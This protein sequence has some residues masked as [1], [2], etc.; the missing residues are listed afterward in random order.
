M[1]AGHKRGRRNVRKPGA[2]ATSLVAQTNARPILDATAIRL[3]T[4]RMATEI[5]ERLGG[6]EPALGSLALVAIRNGGV[7]LTNRIADEIEATEGIRPVIG[8]VDIAL[9]RDDIGRLADPLVGP[10]EIPVS[11]DD[12]AVVLVDDVLFTGRTVRAAIDAVLDYGRPRSIRLAVL[13]DRGHRELPIA[14]DFV[15]RAIVTD[16]RDNVVVA[17]EGV[18]VR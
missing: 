14:A 5:V 18:Y 11:L 3:A 7:A 10:S 9:Y 4:R 2:V 8:T 1:S 17:D 12:K 6:G 13:I 15:G 16:R